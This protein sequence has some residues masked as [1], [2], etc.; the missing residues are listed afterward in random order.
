MGYGC[1]PGDPFCAVTD[2][3]LASMLTVTAWG[4]LLHLV[5]TQGHAQPAL[6]SLGGPRRVDPCLLIVTVLTASSLAYLLS[7]LGH[8]YR[9][10]SD[11]R[12]S[13]AVLGRF[14]DTTTPALTTIVPSTRRMPRSSRTGRG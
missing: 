1:R 10:R 3:R 6:L 11:H 7:R 4:R 2:R 13:R 9:T 14:Y 12:T 5:V 8:F